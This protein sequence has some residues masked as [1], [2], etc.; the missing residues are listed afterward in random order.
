MNYTITDYH[1][2]DGRAGISTKTY[3]VKDQKDIAKKEWAIA[4]EAHAQ[5]FPEVLE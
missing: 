2:Q 1:F 3:D 5:Y 4:R